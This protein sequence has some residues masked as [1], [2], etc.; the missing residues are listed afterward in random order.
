MTEKE[1]VSKYE[2]LTYDL[3]KNV[4]KMCDIYE[5][6][7][8]INSEVGWDGMFECDFGTALEKL[9]NVESAMITYSMESKF[10]KS[11]IDD[12]KSTLHW[13]TEDMK[14]KENQEKDS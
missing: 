2:K 5:Q 4:A 1:A 13:M 6:V 9:A 11:D 10:R 3:A 8:Y 12:L 14:D 7:K